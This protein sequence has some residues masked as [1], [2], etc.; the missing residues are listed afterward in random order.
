MRECE[1]LTNE[2]GVDEM[3]SEVHLRIIE[4]FVIF[5]MRA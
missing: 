5:N 1:S 2:Y 4:T 3:R